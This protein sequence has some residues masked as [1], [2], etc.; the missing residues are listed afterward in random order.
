[1]PVDTLLLDRGVV[2]S[3]VDVGE[4]TEQ[5]GLA[6][7]EYTGEGEPQRVRSALSSE[8]TAM[9]LMPGI[10]SG[11]PAYTVKVH[12]KSPS[13][14]EAIRGVMLLHDLPS[15][16]LLA[17]IDS[18]WL[19]AQR[20]ALTAAFVHD[21]LTSQLRG[22]TAIIGAGVQGTAV[23]LA[24]AHRRGGRFVIYDADQRR[25]F[26]LQQVLGVSNADV[27]PSA[28]AAVRA[29]SSAVTATW[30]REPVASIAAL[31]RLN[32]VTVLGMDEPG[33]QELPP[34]V[35]G[36]ATVYADDPA[37]V[38]PIIHQTALPISAGLK[39]PETLASPSVYVAAGL[40]LLD[41]IAAWHVYQRARALGY[42]RSMDF[43][44][45]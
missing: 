40:P 25:A 23:A 37:L 45:S 11:V 8:L 42:G 29:S 20:T 30:G 18:G 27:A 4:L 28:E 3:V 5:L 24:L 17:V 14:D 19:T 7:L 41:C 35:L 10:A 22:S 33:K 13:A 9:V 32:H 38:R 15:G 1:M 16:D 21:R 36:A 44:A 34:E 43:R 26:A 12:A 39:D 2:R 31:R 6:L